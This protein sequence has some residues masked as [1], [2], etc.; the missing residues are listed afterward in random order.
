MWKGGR[1]EGS[2]TMAARPR[3]YPAGTRRA[4][5]NERETNS[6]NHGHGVPHYNANIRR[7]L[8]T[9]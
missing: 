8:M 7:C 3:R 4:I 2:D 1:E 9:A 5:N 6:M